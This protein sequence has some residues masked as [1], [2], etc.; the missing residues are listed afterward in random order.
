MIPKQN[1]V[2]KNDIW[3]IEA[4]AR[5]QNR[6]STVEHLFA[7]LVHSPHSSVLFSGSHSPSPTKGSMHDEESEKLSEKICENS[8]S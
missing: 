1:I 5:C 2:S 7:S 3:L 4:F 8:N 6:T